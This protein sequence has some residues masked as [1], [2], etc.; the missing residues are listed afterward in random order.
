[1]KRRV[2][3]IVLAVLLAGGGT[4]ALVGYVQAAKRKAVSSEQLTTVYVI[5]AKVSRGAKAADIRSAVKAEQVPTRLKQP[6]AVTDL[7]AV[8]GKVAAVELLPGEQLV[9]PRLT[10]AIVDADVPTDQ[11]QISVLLEPERAVGGQLKAGD[12]VGVF[13]SFDPFEADAAGAL[14]A[15]GSTTTTTAA[16]PAGSTSSSSVA[17]KTPNMTHLEFQK[18]LVTSVRLVQLGTTSFG[19]SG[20]STKDADTSKS[21]AIS[22]D[23]Y[24]VTLALTAKQSEQLVFTAEFGHV[25]L[26][27]QPAEVDES[28]TRIVS[29]GNVYSVRIK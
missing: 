7:A 18:V 20:G 11:M 19:G 8:D 21:A 5:D 28:G 6:G 4:L 15:T 22:N 9:T 29:L 16:Q 17:T 24:V 10:D 14:S 12:K 23:K 25:W 26:A 1:M 3:G 2:M 27:T 13:L